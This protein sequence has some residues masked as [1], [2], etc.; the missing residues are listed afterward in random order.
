MDRL[1]TSGADSMVNTLILVWVNSVVVNVRVSFEMTLFFLTQSRIPVNKAFNS[2]LDLR[3]DILVF[4]FN[5]EDYYYYFLNTLSWN[6][7]FSFI[8]KSHRRIF[9]KCT[10][11]FFI[12]IKKEAENPLLTPKLE[13]CFQY[14]MAGLKYWKKSMKRDFVQ[15]YC[16][17]CVINSYFI[18]L[19]VLKHFFS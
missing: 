1:T 9:V 8:N 11:Q 3:C 17:F 14:C 4:I 6:Q 18:I 7:F 16:H 13:C 5:V 19:K 12:S 15:L 10:Q 2:S